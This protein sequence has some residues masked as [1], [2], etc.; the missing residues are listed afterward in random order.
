MTPYLAK[1]LIVYSKNSF[2][3]CFQPPLLKGAWLK[4]RWPWLQG[5]V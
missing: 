5:Q 4:P 1:F 2:P 3:F